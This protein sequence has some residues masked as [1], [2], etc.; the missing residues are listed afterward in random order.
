VRKR[1]ENNLK[2][3]KMKTITTKVFKINGQFDKYAHEN[4][5][6]SQSYSDLALEMGRN[7]SE[8]SKRQRAN[9]RKR[10]AT[11]IKGINTNVEIF[12]VTAEIPVIFSEYQLKEAAIH[13]I[14]HESRSLFL[15]CRNGKTGYN[16]NNFKIK[17]IK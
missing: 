8:M 5:R 15:L 1:K 16:V 14:I 7:Y 2:I 4:T 10:H 3:C 13:S 17:K 11:K 6:K 12:E 9:F